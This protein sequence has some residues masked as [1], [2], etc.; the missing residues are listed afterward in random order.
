MYHTSLIIVNISLT[1]LR[2]GIIWTVTAK[3]GR[4]LGCAKAEGEINNKAEGVGGSIEDLLRQIDS[5]KFQ[6]LY[7]IPDYT[8]FSKVPD[9]K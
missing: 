5:F 3:L 2:S 8:Q 7:T 9:L 4:D 6:T 1:R